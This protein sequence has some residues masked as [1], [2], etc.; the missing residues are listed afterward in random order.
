MRYTMHKFIMGLSMIGLLA[1]TACEIDTVVDPNN[2]SLGGVTSDASP[3]AMQGL[4]T[5]LEAR[6]RGY[7][8]NA[9]ELFGVLGREAYAFFG[10]DPR[11][12]AD[13][14]GLE[15]DDTYPDF[16]CFCGYLC[17]SLPCRK[18]G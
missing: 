17:Q 7:V 16:F 18:T 4:V 3:V 8:E 6:H 2:P 5:G 15:V 14:L 12:I 10:S 9:G 11:F 1:F 13:W